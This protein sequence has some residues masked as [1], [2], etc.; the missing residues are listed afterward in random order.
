MGSD[1]SKLDVQHIAWAIEQRAEIQRTLLALYDYGTAFG[2]GSS[3]PFKLALFNDLV[4]AAFS[5]W[6]AVFLADQ[7][8]DFGSVHE[9]ATDFLQRVV[10]TNAIT[11][12]D[13]KANSAWSVGYYLDNAKLRLENA[14]KYTQDNQ[15]HPSLPEIEPLLGTVGWH[16]VPMTQYE[17]EA[18]HTALRILFHVLYPDCELP[19][20]Q[21]TP[22]QPQGLEEFMK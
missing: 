4:G 20:R 2:P 5:L 14:R 8:R 16:D 3:S 21:P 22:S 1:K 19:I 15:P 7:I 6:R 17:W 13:D 10:S 9:K 18:A 12:S 11:F